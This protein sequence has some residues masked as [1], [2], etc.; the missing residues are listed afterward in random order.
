MR[1]LK[2]YEGRSGG[3]CWVASPASCGI[4]CDVVHDMSADFL[5]HQM[6][7]Q[8]QKQPRTAWICSLL[9]AAHRDCRCG[10]AAC[11]KALLF[12]ILERRAEILRVCTFA[13][14]CA[15]QV[16]IVTF[17]IPM[18]TPSLLGGW[19]WMGVDK[20]GCSYGGW[21]FKSIH[22]YIY[23]TVNTCHNLPKT[24]ARVDAARTENY[25]TTMNN[26]S[27]NTKGGIELR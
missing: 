19:G 13:H 8:E 21:G 2:R 4:T 15:E 26:S 27:D 9:A 12:H 3:V 25:S 24:I 22:I 16:L 23:I 17:G 14:G 20:G 18:C 10:K 1:S 6:R 11:C 5:V 7:K